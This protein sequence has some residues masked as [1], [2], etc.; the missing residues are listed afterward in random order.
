MI[1]LLHIPVW[2]G[3]GKIK[4]K[5]WIRLET[6]HMF[7]RLSPAFQKIYRWTCRD[8]GSPIKLWVFHD[9]WGLMVVKPIH[10]PISKP[11]K[12]VG[13]SA[14]RRR[15]QPEGAY[16]PPVKFYTMGLRG[17]ISAIG[18]ATAAASGWKDCGGDWAGC[19]KQDVK[20]L[21]H[22]ELHPQKRDLQGFGLDDVFSTIGGK[23]VGC[24]CLWGIW[25]FTHDFCPNW[26]NFGVI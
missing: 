21:G 19:C 22:K 4:M 3:R 11:E 8:S 17:F 2:I 23:C 10:L 13:S 6:S 1:C 25:F 14:Q 20:Q 15:G 26:L 18:L 24:F 5:A 16:G 12:P 9:V 7:T